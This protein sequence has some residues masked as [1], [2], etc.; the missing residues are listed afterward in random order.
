MRR[1]ADVPIGRKFAAV[2][3]LTTC[4]SLLLAGGAFV[5]YDA[6][7]VRQQLVTRLTSLATVIG[8]N[9]TAA[10]SYGDAA[11][12][13]ENLE[14]LSTEP[15][16]QAAAIYLTNGTVFA[17]YHRTGPRAAPY[18]RAAPHPAGVTFENGAI[19]VGVP[20]LLDG[21]RLGTVYVRGDTAELAER[22]RRYLTIVLAVIV[23]AALGALLVAGRLQRI[24]TGPI[25][26]LAAGAERV[27][28]DNDYSLR[29]TPTGCDEVGS[30]IVAFNSMLEEIER[31]DAALTAAKEAAEAANR[32]KSEFL[33]NVSHEIRTPLNGVIGMAE[34]LQ[35][36]RLDPEQRECL[37]TV[38]H[39]AD[40]LLS[41]INDILDIS[42]IEAGRLELEQRSFDLHALA[43]EVVTVFAARARQKGLALGAE[44]EADVPALVV[45]DPLRLRQILLNLI[46]NA[47][48]FTETGRVELGV[49]VLPGPGR[50]AADVRFS[51]TDTG[52]GIAPDKQ[53][54]IF[55]A[56]VQADGS[57]A[58][59]FGGTGLGLSISS[60][61][62]QMMR[63][64]LEVE[65]APG[66]GS[67]FFFTVALPVAARELLTG[68]HVDEAA[69]ADLPAHCDVLLAED[70]LINQRLMVRLLE[71]KGARVT[72]A[73]NGLE[74]LEKHAAQRFD[75]ILMD[76]QMPE[77]DGLA[78]TRALRAREAVSG[79]HTPIVAL[80]AHA[81]QGDRERCLA[82]GMDDYLTKPVRP[83]ELELALRRA[84][85]LDPAANRG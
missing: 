76:V 8:A 68:P 40:V 75:V 54:Q 61:L 19:S 36:T 64:T 57:A 56:F 63:G 44:I 70:N 46:G 22:L 47:V 78:A 35:G 73:A 15:H 10:I 24:I 23:A 21:D 67:R 62:V 34:L 27:T 38:T 16:V 51:V 60:R 72:V 82:A 6:T 55:E 77:M 30:L 50:D 7:S 17:A 58:R 2:V 28:G 74:A 52:I 3:T 37:E 43:N 12:G 85:A 14:T 20:I 53:H 11:R 13:T 5:A 81:M 33:A 32:A 45:G 31:R 1:F 48:K 80:T 9:C 69:L 59:R 71:R 4:G 29:V 65:S 25:L 18:D 39:S 79:T 41:V 42:K 84:L 66:R 26:S 83:Q 49:R